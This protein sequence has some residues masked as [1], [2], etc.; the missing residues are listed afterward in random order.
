MVVRSSIVA[1]VI[2]LF[3]QGVWSAL[4]AANLKTSPAIPWSVPV[5]AFLVWLAWQ[6]LGGKWWPRN[7]RMVKK[8]V[9][10]GNSRW[11]IDRVFESHYLRWV[12]WPGSAPARVVYP[13]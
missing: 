7:T 8:L 13:H 3:L 2:A 9:E 10:Y 4:I 11:N 12:R 6:Y 5:M 1:F